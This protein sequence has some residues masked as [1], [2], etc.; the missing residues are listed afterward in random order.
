MNRFQ[1]MYNCKHSDNGFKP[2]TSQLK[3]KIEKNRFNANYFETR[4]DIKE[5]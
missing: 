4:F 3:K 5:I 2:H 1:N